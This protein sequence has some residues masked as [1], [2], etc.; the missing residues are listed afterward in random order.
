MLPHPATVTK[1]PTR[2]RYW[3][4]VFAITLAII[5][6]VDRVSLSFASL[7][8][9][10]DLGLSQAQMGWAFG[11]FGLAYA[12]FELPGGFL[13]DWLGPRQVLLRIVVWWSC[14]TAATGSVFNLV[15]LTTTQFLFGAGEAGC[16]PNLTKAFTTWL[17]RGEKTRAQGFMWLA[18]RWGGA[19]TPPLVRLVMR[20]AGWRNAFRLFGLIGIVWA[21][22]F[23]RWYRN[24][25]LENPKL[26][27][28]ERELLQESRTLA[29]TPRAH[30]LGALPAL[31]PDLAAVLGSIFP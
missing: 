12:L 9:R 5:T 10:R 28:A 13:G 18:A 15:S 3:V 19:F 22:L 4:I 14:C 17:P 1:R 2:V 11:A 6:Y 7:V 20:H 16:F 25:P 24:D 26:N 30:T 21:M 23:Y 29:A 31:A 8:I 27:Q